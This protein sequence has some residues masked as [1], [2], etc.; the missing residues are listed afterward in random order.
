METFK[1]SCFAKLSVPAL[2]LGLPMDVLNTIG[3]LRLET[4]SSAAAAATASTTPATKTAE[5]QEKEGDTDV[6][7]GEGT[8]VHE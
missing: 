8:P 5:K 1:I 6:P 3:V 2:A 7:G 4:P